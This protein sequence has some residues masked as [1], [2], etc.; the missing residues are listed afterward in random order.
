[1]RKRNIF[2][3]IVFPVACFSIPLFPVV[4]RGDGIEKWSD[5]PSLP[6]ETLSANFCDP[7]FGCRLANGLCEFDPAA[8]IAPMDCVQLSSDVRSCL[9]FESAA[10]GFYLWI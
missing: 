6:C 7:R 10:I 5:W 3:V 2:A 1:M 8:P 9:I 4:K